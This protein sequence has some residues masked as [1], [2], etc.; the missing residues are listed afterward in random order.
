[1]HHDSKMAHFDE[2]YREKVILHD[3]SRVTLRPVRPDD[4]ALLS[5]GFKRLSPESRYRRFLAAKSD[6]TDAELAYLTE[7]D[8]HDHFAMGAV[9][10][11]ENGNEEG[12][13]IA[14]FIRSKIDPCV[15]EVAVAVIDDWQSK[16][17]GT[18]LLLRLVAAARERGIERF[19]GVALAANA[20]IRDVLAQL[21]G[22]MRMRSEG[23][24]LAIEVEL[25]E[26]P[27]DGTPKP[28]ERDTPLRHL[29]RLVARGL[30]LARHA[31]ARLRSGI[32]EGAPPEHAPT[33]AP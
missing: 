26:V 19:A 3:G 30:L 9:V 13:A 24:D 28:E 15:A 22:G 5:R 33:G 18:L 2:H 12:V 29:F 7:V 23:N 1:M 16:G 11:D 4:K 32:A 25:P 8:G 20:A 31:V 10:E 17:L 27:V 14:R 21:P 6:L